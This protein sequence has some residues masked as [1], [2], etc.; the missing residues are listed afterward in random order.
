MKPFILRKGEMKGINTHSGWMITEK[1]PTMIV[2]KNGPIN[3]KC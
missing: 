1:Q 2:K 3:E